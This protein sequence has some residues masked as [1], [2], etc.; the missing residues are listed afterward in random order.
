MAS[1]GVHPTIDCARRNE[2]C[3]GFAGSPGGSRAALLP[4]RGCP[5]FLL[6]PRTYK[7]KAQFC[8][9]VPDVLDLRSY[10]RALHRIAAASQTVRRFSN[11]YL[12]R[13]VGGAEEAG[14]RFLIDLQ[15]EDVASERSVAGCLAIAMGKVAWDKQ[16]INRSVI[17]KLKGDYPEIAV[18]RAANTYLGQS[19]FVRSKKGEGYA[20]QRA[21]VPEL[22]AANLATERHWCTN[23]AGLGQK[24]RG[25]ERMNSILRG[26]LKAMNEAMKDADDQTVIRVFHEAWRLTMGEIVERASRGECV[27]EWTGTD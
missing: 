22:I 10:A 21:A 23:F 19:R 11:T 20:F 2:R 8:L 18:F 17:V 13:I 15:A 26:G 3:T 5:I 12:G 16:Q 27:F 9:I 24:K 1:D 4:D 6:R 7:E 25:F 14:L